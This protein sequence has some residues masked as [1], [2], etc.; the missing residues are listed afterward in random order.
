MVFGDS[1]GHWEGDTLVVETT[2][3]TDK[4]HYWWA[5]SWRASRPSLRLVERFKRIDADTIDYQFT[6]EDPESFTRPWTAAI[7]MTT[8][9]AERGVT[10]GRM[11]EFACHEGNYGLVNVLRGARAQEKAAEEAAKKQK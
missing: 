1:R 2:N 4:S 5:Q 8:N 10:S 11:F 6:M 9:Q 7:P 3:F